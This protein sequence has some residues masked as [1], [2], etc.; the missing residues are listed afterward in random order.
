MLKKFFFKSLTPV[1][2]SPDFLMKKNAKI[3]VLPV[4]VSDLQETLFEEK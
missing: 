2:N 1:I 3:K 4:K